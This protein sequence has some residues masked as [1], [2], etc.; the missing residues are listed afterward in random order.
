M[1]Y[2]ML[3]DA[4][5]CIGCQGCQVSC[6]NWNDR[7]GERTMLGDTFG[8]P[9][10]LDSSTYTVCRFKEGAGPEGIEW[11]FS[12]VQCMHCAEPACVAACPCGALTKSKLGPVEYNNGLCIGC[13]Y[14]M[15]ACPFQ[16]PTFEWKSAL[17]YIQ[18]CSFCS[19]RIRNGIEPACSR[20]CAPGALTFGRRE[21]L[22]KIAEDRINARPDKYINYIYGKD[23]VGGTSWLY[24]SDTDFKNLSLRE[25]VEKGN[26][27]NYSWK[28]IS[29]TPAI[30]IGAAVLIAGFFFIADRRDRNGEGR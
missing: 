4:V 22:L 13:R 17:P 8:N 20:T 12:K 9:K 24:I 7:P 5:K 29:R 26:Y 14:C 6:K 30:G 16:V 19:D 1:S 15:L 3:V 23:E 2:A 10:G 21:D 28:A 18:K 11:H 27:A 25:D